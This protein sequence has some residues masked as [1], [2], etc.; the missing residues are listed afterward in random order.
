MKKKYQKPQSIVIEMM[1]T[2]TPL[3]AGSDQYRVNDYYIESEE[4]LGG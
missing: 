1:Q 2:S 3:L 4:N